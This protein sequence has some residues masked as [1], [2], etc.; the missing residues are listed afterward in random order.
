MLAAISLFNLGLEYSRLSITYGVLLSAV[1]MTVERVV[2]REYETRMRRKGV[3]TENVLMVGAGRSAELIIQRMNMFPQYGYKVGAVLDDEL[4]VGSSLA[5]VTVVGRPGPLRGR[6]RR[7]SGVHR[8]PREP[9]RKDA[10]AD[11]ALRRQAA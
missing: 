3:G 4:E 1:L 2:L 8:P 7:G 11:Q 6:A 9:A 5:G 10:S